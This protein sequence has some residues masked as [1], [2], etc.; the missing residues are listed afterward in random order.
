[1]MTKMMAKDLVLLEKFP[2]TSADTDVASRL[3]PGALVNFL[4]QSAIR[5]ADNLGFGFECLQKQNLFWV[6]S[7]LTFEI[8]RP[9]KWYEDTEIETWPKDLHKLL[10]LRD[11]LIRDKDN[12]IIGRATSSWFAIDLIHHRPHKIET[13]QSGIFSF[14]R[15]KHAL[16]FLPEKLDAVPEGINTD[17]KSTYFDIDLNG[18]VTSTRYVDWMMDCIPLEFHLNHYPRGLTV[19]YLKEINP[20][21]LIRIRTFRSHR[22][23]FCFE[24]I[25]ASKCTVCFRGKICF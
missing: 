7:S 19:N 10:Y 13:D 11:F 16:D 20:G 23:C 5:S 6:L 3:R 24:G 8:D 2:V 17:I 14:L 15:E 1:M 9:L 22:N 4:I 18:H 21:E 12:E 25:N